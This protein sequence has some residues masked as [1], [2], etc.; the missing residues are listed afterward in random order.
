VEKEWNRRRYEFHYLYAC[1]SGKLHRNRQRE[2][3]QQQDQRSCYR[4]RY[5]T[6]PAYRNGNHNRN[7]AG[8]TDAHGKYCRAFRRQRNNFLPMET[9]R[10][11]QHRLKQRHLSSASRRWGFNYYRNCVLFGKFRQR[12]QRG[13][14]NTGSSGEYQPYGQEHRRMER[15][16]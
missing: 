10:K 12:Y 13:Y 1:R 4:Y 9:E 3:L 8:G 16:S 5:F 2:R 7:C 6:F 11:R 14:T 15:R